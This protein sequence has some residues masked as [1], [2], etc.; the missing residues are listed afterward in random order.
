MLFGDN[1][2]IKTNVHAKDN[3][4]EYYRLIG[5]AYSQRIIPR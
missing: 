2:L 3:E 5:A 4:L 1:Q